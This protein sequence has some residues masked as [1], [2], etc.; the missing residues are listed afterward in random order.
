MVRVSEGGATRM[1]TAAE[2]F[3]FYL[4]KEAVKDGG[5]PAGRACLDLIQ[6]AEQRASN[7]P[8]IGAIVLAAVA[9][10]SV[11]GALELLRMAKKWIL[12]GK[13]RGSC[14]SPGSSKRPW[15][16]LTGGSALPNSGQW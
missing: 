12:I 10:G 7:L 16:D 15:L 1:V 2:A 13:P 5:G 6:G 9:P 11:T 3:L 14:W 8:R 4:K